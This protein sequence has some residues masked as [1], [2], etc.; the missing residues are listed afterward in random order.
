MVTQVEE[1]KSPVAAELFL[2]D[3]K[4]VQGSQFVARYLG[5]LVPSAGLFGPDEFSACEVDRYTLLISSD[6]KKALA[7]V[8][9]RL[10]TAAFL[11]GDNLTIADLVAFESLVQ[12]G[13][14]E[15]DARVSAWGDKLRT[16]EAFSVERTTAFV[17]VR[18]VI[19]HDLKP[20]GKCS[21][22]PAGDRIRTRYESPR[23]STSERAVLAVQH[24]AARIAASSSRPSREPN[25]H[26][27]PR[28]VAPLQ[29]RVTVLRN[30]LQ[31]VPNV[32]CHVAAS[33]PNP[34]ATSTSA[35]LSRFASTSGW[36]SSTAAGVT[37]AST[38][39]TP[40]R[41]CGSVRPRPRQRQRQRRA[42]PEHSSCKQYGF[43]GADRVGVK[44]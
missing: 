41:R 40:A 36:R 6:P 14:A 15:A 10:A 16:S 21:L 19:V 34:T 24:A 29:H 5:R 43:A 33:H 7:E 44:K 9:G 26:A 37:C 39:P 25:G 35:T 38:T 8:S 13:A 1:N 2:A 17:D 30:L 27:T 22:R 4:T 3:G 20:G 23:C 12:T 32:L 31:S 42:A 11:V 28:Q 18:E